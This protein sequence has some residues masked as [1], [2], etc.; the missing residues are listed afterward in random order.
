MSH[1]S[2]HPAEFMSILSSSSLKW[3]I[4]I[5][6]SWPQTISK[7]GPQALLTDLFWNE[8]KNKVP[9][10]SQRLSQRTAFVPMPTDLLCPCASR[11]V[12]EMCTDLLY[13][14]HTCTNG[15]PSKCVNRLGVYL[16][17][18]VHCVVHLCMSLLLSG[19]NFPH[20]WYG[21]IRQSYTF[22]QTIFLLSIFCQELWRAWEFT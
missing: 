8:T 2:N 14:L 9:W 11:I 6:Q 17:I 13:M 1:T 20:Q 19:L 16:Q 21:N 5:V 4:L 12:S 7:L 22:S 3:D 10:E 18:A 15:Q